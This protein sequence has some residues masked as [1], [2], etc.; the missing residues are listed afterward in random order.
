V[1]VRLR[2]TAMAILAVM[3]SAVVLHSQSPINSWVIDS[4]PL[5]SQHYFGETV[6]NGMLGIRSSADPFRVSQILLNGAYEPL[7][8]GG[9][10]VIERTLNFL[11]MTLF[12]DGAPIDRADQVTALH[13][14][15]D[16][17][18][19]VLT[20]AFDYG[21][22]ATIVTSL[23]ALRQLPYTAMLEVRVTA[24]QPLTLAAATHFVS[25]FARE[26]PDPQSWHPPLTNLQL[27]SN[28]PNQE[29]LV[30]AAEATGP[31]GRLELGASQAFRFD[32]SLKTPPQLA[33]DAGGQKFTQQIGAGSTFRFA[34]IGSSLSSAHVADPLSEAQRLTATAWF[35]GIDELIQKHEEA[36]ADLWKS[37]IVIAGDDATQRSVRSMIYHLYSFIR[38]GSRLSISPMG[39]SRDIM[40]YN[41]HVFW[42]AETWMY[43]PLL[44]LHPELARSML[45]YRYDRLPAAKQN[46][47]ANGYRGALY[48]WESAGSGGEDTPLC[49][50]SIEIHINADIGI[51]AWQ[52]Y[53]V[54][55]DR[56]W[57][58]DRGYP[59]I[60]ATADFWA[61]RVTRHQSG[62]FNIN[63]VLAA[64]EYSGAVDD[65]AF[66]NAAAR[67]NLLDAIAA[68]QALGLKPNPDWQFVHDR[69]PILKFPDGVTREF[70][71]YHGQTVKQADVNMLAY[72]LHEITDTGAIRRDLDYYAPRV[73]P[74]G[75]AMTKSVLA[76]L[77]ERMGDAA[78]AIEL[79]H[80]GYQLNE[81]PPFGSLSE[82]ANNANPYFATAAG[83]LLQTMLFGF[84]GLDISDHG[85]IQKPSKLP[86][87]WKSLTLTG[88]GADH[89]DYVVR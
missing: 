64:D 38:A 28:K 80:R 77:H 85:L 84:G 37:D 57:L 67:Q 32:D 74:N 70:A 22:K 1:N 62:A 86:E 25:T 76:I 17:K 40:G 12:I 34:L 55:K 18:R 16:M 47:F 19:A 24:R 83:G 41:G 50:L 75:P 8:P 6:A 60:E 88:I 11:D 52:Y 27:F 33:L 29:V 81:R 4:G 39:L 21:G 3:T 72:P 31:M 58:R 66:T 9:V 36:W 61:S 13:Q 63:H 30:T 56:E 43:P 48:P 49:C 44:L 89:H 68:A 51:A 65:N 7:E 59:I 14:T 54:T 71:T 35:D 73:D 78:K 10:D 79:F 87:G 42:D 20:T 26:S 53:L 15:L 5:D 45:D 46:A 82:T 69:I 2:K 23:R